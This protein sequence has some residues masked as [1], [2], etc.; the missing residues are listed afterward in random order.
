M[1]PNFLKFRVPENGMFLNQAVH[2]F[3]T[4]LLRTEINKVRTDEKN[5]E[6]KLER[7]RGA[8]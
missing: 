8:V 2:S 4:K 3:Q 5:V 6:G 7:T 1:K